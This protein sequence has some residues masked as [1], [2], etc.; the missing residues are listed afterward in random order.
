MNDKYTNN[1]IEKFFGQFKRLPDCIELEK[2]HHLV[3]SPEAK[4][5]LSGKT[6]IKPFNLIIMTT[7]FITGLTV[8]TLWL[9]PTKEDNSSTIRIQ[10]PA[11]SVK[12]ER[13]IQNQKTSTS[14]IPEKAKPTTVDV[15]KSKKQDISIAPRSAMPLK[16]EA[17]VSASTNK[18]LSAT[19]CNWPQDTMLNKR[20]LFVR[21]TEQELEK[22]GLFIDVD[23]SKS[24][25][26]NRY[27]ALYNDSMFRHYPIYTHSYGRIKTIK[28]TATFNT[29]YTSDTACTSERWDSPFYNSIDTLIPVVRLNRIYWVNPIQGVFDSLPERYQY[30]RVYDKIPFLKRKVI[31]L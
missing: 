23:S 24:S 20:S 29:C 30:L 4:A 25:I 27:K 6:F 3:K 17:N 10:Q 11:D 13:K 5:R 7:T 18:E 1:D 14:V 19:I 16:A 26:I 31:L 8:L 12:I 15:K 28:Y 22:V 21:L 9:S 2:V